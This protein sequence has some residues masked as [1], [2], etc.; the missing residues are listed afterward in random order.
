MIWVFS[1]ILLSVELRLT[2]RDWIFKVMFSLEVLLQPSNSA[3]VSGENGKI[4]ALNIY[5]RLYNND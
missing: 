1:S 4:L 5:L 3:S 2:Q